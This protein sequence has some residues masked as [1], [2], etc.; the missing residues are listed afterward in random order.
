[1]IWNISCTCNLQQIR[2]TVFQAST[3][4][5][6]SNDSDVQQHPL[7]EEDAPFRK[8]EWHQHSSWFL[9][10]ARSYGSNYQLLDL[11][12]SLL[13]F[14]LH[15]VRYSHHDIPTSAVALNAPRG[16]SGN[17]WISIIDLCD[18]KGRVEVTRPQL[19]YTKKSCS[20]L[21]LYVG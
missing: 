3:W 17:N 10:T 12:H 21:S 14:T 2:K 18:L 8:Q 9:R 11:D 1:M 20:T 7:V 5:A 15:I 19:W 4:D 13:H 16:M 6:C